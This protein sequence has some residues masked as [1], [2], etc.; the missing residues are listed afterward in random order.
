MTSAMFRRKLLHVL[1]FKDHGE[2]KI[3]VKVT[4]MDHLIAWSGFFV[5]VGNTKRYELELEL[6]VMKHTSNGNVR[7]KKIQHGGDGMVKGAVNS[8]GWS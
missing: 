3:C 8:G 2:Q 6:K 1:F 4:F 7:D 5:S